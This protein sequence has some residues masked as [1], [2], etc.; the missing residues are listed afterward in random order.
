MRKWASSSATSIGTEENSL[1]VPTARG[2]ALMLRPSTRRSRCR[3]SVSRALGEDKG[4]QRSSL[5][6]C[7]SRAEPR[8]QA[9]LSGFRGSQAIG[10]RIRD[11]QVKEIGREGLQTQ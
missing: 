5:L 10:L 9:W 1:G 3:I 8:R 4:T 11:S 7:L 6:S 2:R